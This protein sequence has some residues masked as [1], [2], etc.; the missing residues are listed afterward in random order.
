M[1]LK[2]TIESDILNGEIVEYLVIDG[3][4]IDDTMLVIQAPEHARART[5]TAMIKKYGYNIPIKI[6]KK[7]CW[8]YDL[9]DKNV[10]EFDLI[11]VKRETVL[12]SLDKRCSG[13]LRVSDTYATNNC[14][15]F[16]AGANPTDRFVSLCNLE[17]GI[18]RGDQVKSAWLILIE[19]DSPEVF[20][21]ASDFGPDI[22][23]EMAKGHIAIATRA[24]QRITRQD[25]ILP[26][27]VTY[28]GKKSFHCL[29]QFDRPISK[30]QLDIFD[31]AKDFVYKELARREK[32]QLSELDRSLLS[33]DKEPFFSGHALAR[34]PCRIAESGRFPQ[35][36]WRT[37]H[38]GIIKVDD[39]INATNPIIEHIKK[40]ESLAAMQRQAFMAQS[41][42]NNFREKI[43][44]AD[45][46]AA[47]P[48]AKARNGDGYAVRCPFHDDKTHSAF[49]SANGFI[50]CSVCCDANNRYVGR[51]R[52]GGNVEKT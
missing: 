30:T 49:V 15:R 5:L 22:L 25:A 3:L 28:S 19:I 48:D 52:S 17:N 24:L 35:I 7:L 31:K 26:F 32:S 6:N 1:T 9:L 46:L 42:Q 51:V 45:L 37:G 33:I 44:D 50:Y 23:P 11:P 4:S 47:F 20:D 29:W 16:I 34:I 13:M 2:F 39:L 36:G 8:E 21:A 12:I 43:T 41:S 10:P 38:Q 40:L 27:L 14:P 18:K